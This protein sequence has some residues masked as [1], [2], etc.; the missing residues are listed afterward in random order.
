MPSNINIL[1][2]NDK[3]VINGGSRSLKFAKNTYDNIIGKGKVTTGDI[4]KVVEESA[5]TT[6]TTSVI[7]TSISDGKVLGDSYEV[8]E[9]KNG[10]VYGEGNK[11][12]KVTTAMINGI[13]SHRITVLPNIIPQKKEEI[14]IGDIDTGLLKEEVKGGFDDSRRV[15]PLAGSAP[16]RSA[17]FETT[18]VI[19]EEDKKIKDGDTISDDGQKLT[20]SLYSLSGNSKPE[21]SKSPIVKEDKINAPIIN[22]DGLGDVNPIEVKEKP[23]KFADEEFL[24]HINTRFNPLSDD[25]ESQNFVQSSKNETDRNINARF[26]PLSDN[27]GY[28]G[29]QSF[30]QISEPNSSSVQISEDVLAD[31]KRGFDEVKKKEREN[32]EAKARIEEKAKALATLN[33]EANEYL[34]GL[35]GELA[36][37]KANAKEEGVAVAQTAADTDRRYYAIEA[38]LKA[39]EKLKETNSE[40][41]GETYSTGGN[42]S[43]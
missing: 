16:V 39:L 10:E 37:R 20:D 12:I 1:N 13:R 36:I 41:T 31:I 3:E 19:P 30:T 17:K 14:K 15:R 8:I 35:E 24:K 4:K 29:D 23:S 27:N 18:P 38:K 26:N 43:R 7:P 25:E 28:E 32:A 34:K 33:E 11:A 5:H 22:V 42:K 21:G 40:L 9:I 6:H 2:K